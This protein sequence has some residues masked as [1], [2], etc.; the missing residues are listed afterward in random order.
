M[1]IITAQCLNFSPNELYKHANRDGLYK[2]KIKSPTQTRWEE[3]V[4]SQINMEAYKA[5]KFWWA[6]CIMSGQFTIWDYNGEIY[7]CLES[8]GDIKLTEDMEEIKLSEYYKI[9]EEIEDES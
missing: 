2:F 9:I 8:K 6:P 1:K 4:I 7:G 5:I 3:E